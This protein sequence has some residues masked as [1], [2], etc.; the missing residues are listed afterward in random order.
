M[1]KFRMYNTRFYETIC[2]L[3][4]VCWLYIAWLFIGSRD[5]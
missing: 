3:F 1:G 4:D 5:K 2:K